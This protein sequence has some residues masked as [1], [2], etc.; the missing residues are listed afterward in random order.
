ML[1]A[2][3]F[4]KTSS[5]QSVKSITFLI[6]CTGE[7]SR[8]LEVVCI[9]SLPL[10]LHSSFACL[11]FHLFS[12]PYIWFTDYLLTGKAL[13]IRKK[14]LLALF[15][16]PFLFFFSFRSP[17]SC[18]SSLYFSKCIG[19]NEVSRNGS[20]EKWDKQEKTGL[21]AMTAVV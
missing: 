4:R 5:C 6:S 9:P 14:P 11:L 2:Y 19:L 20:L 3:H 15:F 16:F 17:V 1:F 10:F 21:L 8:L 18:S 12:L 13:V 7:K